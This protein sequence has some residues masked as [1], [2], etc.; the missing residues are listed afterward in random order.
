MWHLLY[1]EILLIDKC[2]LMIGNLLKLYFFIFRQRARVG[3]RKGE[4]HQCVVASH[5]PHTGKPGPQP[6]NEPQLGIEP[7]TLCFT[8]RCSIH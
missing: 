7:A 2:L 6:R 8:V 5:V 1:V 3:E 4:K